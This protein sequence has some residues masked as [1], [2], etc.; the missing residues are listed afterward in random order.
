MSFQSISGLKCPRCHE[1]RM[2]EKG[3]YTRKFMEM[4]EYCPK[5]GFKF[6]IEPGF[7]WGS[8]YISYGITV[9]ISLVIG[10]AIYVFGHDPAIWVYIS[11]V[12]VILIL[13]S[14]LVYRFSRAVMLYAFGSVHYDPG[15]ARK[16]Q[17][18]R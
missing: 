5:C 16:Y 4:N 15:A 3:P 13:L 9:L 8:M 17:A 12:S 14:P 7:F 10:I 1:G 18:G 11:T 6:E 2:F